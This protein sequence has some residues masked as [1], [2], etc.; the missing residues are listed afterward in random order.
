[1]RECE[2]LFRKEIGQT[3]EAHG[4]PVDF[5]K[6]SENNLFAKA[7]MVTELVEMGFTLEAIE[8]ILK[9]DSA[10]LDRLL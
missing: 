10:V 6:I 2:A 9:L 1:M 4:S 7:A 3:N 5:G 8:R